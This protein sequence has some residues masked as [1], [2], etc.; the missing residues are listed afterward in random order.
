M[1]C[2]GCVNNVKTVMKKLPGV[3]H[4]NVT[5]DPSQATIEFDPNKI[6][7][8]QIKAA[9]INTGFDVAESITAAK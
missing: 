3:S 5:L 8:D 6:T 7:I 9:I 2:M 4:T 1:T